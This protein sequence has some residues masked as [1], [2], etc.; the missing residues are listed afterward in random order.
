MS[1]SILTLLSLLLTICTTS[2]VFAWSLWGSDEPLLSINGQEYTNSDYINWWREWR[3]DDKLPPSAD[4]YIDW[5]LLATEAEQ[6]QLQDRPSYQQK[7]TT[8]IK[9]RSLMLLKKEEIDDKTV[10]ADEKELHRIYLSDYAPRWQLR[11]ITFKNYPDLSAFMAAH[12]SAPDNTTEDILANLTVDSADYSLSSTVNERPNHLPEQIVNLLQN[13]QGQRFSAPYPWQNTWQIIEIITTEKESEADFNSLRDSI[14][15][16][17]F[18]QQQ[19]QLTA[20]LLSKLREKYPVTLDNDI[21][22]AMDASGVPE[23]K[24]NAIVMELLDAKITASQL[25]NLAIQQYN[26]L[27]AQQKNK[28]AFQQRLQQIIGGIISQNLTNTEALKRNYQNQMPFKATFDFYCKHRLIREL[29]QQLIMSQVKVTPDEV[30]QAYEEHKLEMS[31]P[32]LIEVIRASTNDADL[33]AQLR[34]QIRQ[35]EDFSHILAILGYTN[36]QSEKLPLAHLSTELQQQLTTMQPLQNTMV[37]EQGNFTF[38]QLIKPPQVDLIDFNEI[39]PALTEK[40]K[41]MAIKNKRQSIIQQLRQR[42]TISVNQKQ[43]QHCLDTI[44]K[45]I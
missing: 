41:H 4:S 17:N 25:Y 30:K 38:V 10:I 37:E 43:W 33:A 14:A 21:I 20:T 9:V 44:K 3:E 15:H 2:P 45:G 18:K 40:L 28:V 29:E 19:A 24:E 7:I 16:R 23:G 36:A 22:E 1:K 11:T 32:A 26:S 5:L 6:M 31:G 34:D 12:K 42:S 27:S 8:F 35:G 13:S 39:K